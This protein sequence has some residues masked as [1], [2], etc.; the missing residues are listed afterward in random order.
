MTTAMANTI[1]NA[2]VT[3]MDFNT[4]LATVKSFTNDIDVIFPDD[5]NYGSIV[6]GNIYGNS[7]TIDFDDNDLV[8]TID[9]DDGDWD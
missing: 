9:V 5:T 1:A 6:V 4:A 8:D 3:G 7:V 2:I